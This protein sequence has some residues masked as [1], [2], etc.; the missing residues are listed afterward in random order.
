MDKMQRSVKVTN[1]GGETE[2]TFRC[3]IPGCRK[4]ILCFPYGNFAFHMNNT[5]LGMWD[6]RSEIYPINQNVESTDESTDDD[7]DVVCMNDYTGDVT[8][9]DS[10]IENED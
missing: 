6:H 1:R 10:D 7:D 4:R 8:A 5:H 3:P 2:A 9:S